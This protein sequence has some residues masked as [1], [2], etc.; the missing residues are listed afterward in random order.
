MQK[1][2]YGLESFK[3]EKS[4][5]VGLKSKEK[6]FLRHSCT[7]FKKIYTEHKD[8]SL[9]SRIRSERVKTGNSN[10]IRTVIKMK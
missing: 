10:G 8:F 7:F 2:L 6:N 9:L 4:V 1:H 3:T 5:K